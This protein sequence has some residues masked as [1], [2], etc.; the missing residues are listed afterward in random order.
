M[1]KALVLDTIQ[2]EKNIQ[3]PKAWSAVSISEQKRNEHAD[4]CAWQGAA[5]VLP[6]VRAARTAQVRQELGLEQMPHCDEDPEAI[7]DTGGSERHSSDSRSST[8][9]ER[10][11]SGDT[12]S[13][14]N[15]EQ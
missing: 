3:Q 1:Y 13:E 10:Y 8:S 14:S 5:I 15:C 11:M 9:E 2:N 6:Q 4:Q 7:C 12:D